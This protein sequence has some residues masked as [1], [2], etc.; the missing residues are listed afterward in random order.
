MNNLDKELALHQ[1]D[2]E[3]QE[4][5]KHRIN[6]RSYLLVYLLFFTLIIPTI[7]IASPQEIFEGLYQIIISPSNLTTDYFVVGGLGGS[8]V[9]SA[10]IL[11]IYTLMVRRLDVDMSG[12]IVAA[13][14]LMAGFALFGKNLYNSFPI[15][16]GVYLNSKYTRQPFEKNLLPA[17]YATALGPLVSQITFGLDIPLWLGVVLGICVGV[18]VGFIAPPLAANTLRFHAGFNLYNVGFTAGLIGMLA[19]AVL[20]MFGHEIPAVAI[21]FENPTPVLN[22]V[23]MISWALF[24][25]VGAI[26]IYRSKYSFSQFIELTNNSGRLVADFINIYGFEVTLLNMGLMGLIS[27]T[28]VILINGNLTGPTL[29]GILTVVG[30]SAFGKHVKNAPPIMLGVLIASLFTGGGPG[31]NA[32]LLGALF[33][34]ALAPISGH[35]GLISGIVAG[36]FHYAMVVNVSYL[37]AGVNLYNNGFSAGFIAAI[38]V[39]IFDTIEEAR[40]SRQNEHE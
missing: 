13:L 11:I 3:E 1:Q 14:F 5:E 20:R 32:A 27:T 15:T 22:I 38:L 2:I 7:I 18:I 36:F 12:S 29:G 31:T 35:Y 37:H 16:L 4:L 23:V 39:P 19:V 28:Y 24:A 17:M 25:V 6:H 8:L 33:G 21:V 10:L 26:L 40:R 34:T 30:F 9:N